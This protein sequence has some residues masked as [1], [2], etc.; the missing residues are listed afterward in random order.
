ME[1]KKADFQ[2]DGLEGIFEG[3]T[4]GEK[5][6]GYDCPSFTKEVAFKI[7]NAWV[8]AGKGIDETYEGYYKVEEDAF[9]LDNDPDLGLPEKVA[10]VNIHCGGDEIHVYPIGSRGWVWEEVLEEEIV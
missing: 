3:Y 9:Y 2:I 5:W 8:K 6:N 7:I 10:G 1:F 4:K